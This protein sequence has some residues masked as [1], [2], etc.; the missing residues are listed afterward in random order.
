M[1]L[2]NAL[3]GRTTVV[4]VT[5]RPSHMR[6]VDRVVELRGGVVAGDGKPEI[7]VPRILAKITAHNSAGFATGKDRS[8]A[9]DERSH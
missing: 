7:I 3:R 9:S 5:A 6:I 1:A 2:L 4:L 8:G